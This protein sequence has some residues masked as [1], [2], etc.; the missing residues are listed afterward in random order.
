M[1]IQY[2]LTMPSRG[3]WDGRWTGEDKLY[4]R[5]KSYSSKIANKILCDKTENAWRYHW[6]DGWTALIEGKIIDSKEAAKIRRKSL[7]FC[8]YDWMIDSIE[9]HGNIIAGHLK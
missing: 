7:G 1:I 9:Q 8:G 4:A 6:T 3:S 5:C 2:T